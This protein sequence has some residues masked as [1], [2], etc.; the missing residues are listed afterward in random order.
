MTWTARTAKRVFLSQA[1]TIRFGSLELVCPDRTYC[2]SGR[3]AG[4]GGAPRGDR[5]DAQ[6][7]RS[8]RRHARDCVI[9]F[10]GE[11]G[12]GD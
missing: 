10:L 2:F 1:E 5:D 6:A 9:R 11:S 4:A 8:A 7:I 12:G 3:D